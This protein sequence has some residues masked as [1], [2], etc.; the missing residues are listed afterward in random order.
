MKTT[1]SGKSARDR[2]L[3]EALRDNLRRRKA[4]IWERAQDRETAVVAPERGDEARRDAK[5]D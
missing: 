2:R 3:A 1:T 5:G 4:Q